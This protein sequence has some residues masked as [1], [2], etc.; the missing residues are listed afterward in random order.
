MDVARC[1]SR[2]AR[3][4]QQCCAQACAQVRFSTRNM[5]QHVATGWPNACNM[6][7]PTMLRFVALKCCD[8]LSGACKC[9]A[10][11]VGIC[12]VE[13]LLSFG[14]GLSQQQPTCHN[15][16]QH[17]STGWSNARNMLR[18]TIMRYVVFKCWNRL[19]GALLSN[20]ICSTLHYKKLI[21]IS[22]CKPSL[23]RLK[24]SM[25][26]TSTGRLFHIVVPLHL[27]KNFA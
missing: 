5:S 6:L 14:R 25:F 8:R 17:F 3:F 23:K 22:N 24:E 13:M 12:C 2:L 18:P 16:S 19:A 10:N 20:H 27:R 26:L 4:V 1:C 7:R 21:W 15:M 11:I 9:W